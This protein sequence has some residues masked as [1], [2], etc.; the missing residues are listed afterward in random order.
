MALLGRVKKRLLHY[1]WELAYG[2][3]SSTI[4]Y[5]GIACESLHIIKNPYKGQKWFADPFIL[6]Y[7]DD[8]V[9]FLVEEFDYSFGHGRIARIAVDR[10]NDT[11]TECSII[12]ELPTHLSFP[13]IY[14]KDGKVYVHPENFASGKSVIYEYNRQEDKLINPVTV[15][16]LPLTDAI[17]RKYG[18]GYEISATY[19]SDPNGSKL[20]K[21]VSRDFLGLY[22]EESVDNYPNKSARMAGY[23]IEAGGKIVRPAQ[24]CNGDYGRSVWFYEGMRVIGRLIP[25][26]S[27]AGIHTFNTLDDIFVIDLKK[28]DYPLIYNFKNKIEK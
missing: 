25:W 1:S 3:F 8:I 14:R 13:A 19:G 28:Y 16:N 22:K 20:N 5:D 18:D 21:L 23:Y 27:Y 6:E 4:L 9:T 24:D 10:H 7:N 15:C 17:I 2:A 26:G 12:L 11:I